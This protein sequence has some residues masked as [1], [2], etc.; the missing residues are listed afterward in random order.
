MS[1]ASEAHHHIRLL[2]ELKDDLHMWAIFLEKFNGISYFPSR[3]W[4][5]SDVLEL[6]TD[7]TGNAEL[8]CGAYFQGRWAFFE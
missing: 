5:S 3:E 1:G 7:S 8:G 2:S 4:I 6:F